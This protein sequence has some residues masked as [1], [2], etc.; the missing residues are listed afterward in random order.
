MGDELF[1]GLRALAFV[2]V[3]RVEHLLERPLR[4]LIVA[5]LAGA[6]LAVPVEAEA[7]LVQ[8]LAVAL[9]VRLGGD[10]R[11]LTCLYGILL[12][13]QAIG[14]VAHRVEH[15]EALLALEAR[16]DIAGDVSQRMSHMQSGTARVGEHVEHVVLFLRCILGHLVG[17]LF[18]PARL[19]LLLN[20]SEI[21]IHCLFVY[22]FFNFSI[23]TA[24]NLHKKYEFSICISHFFSFLL[25]LSIPSTV[26]R[27][28]LGPFLSVPIH[29]KRRPAGGGTTGTAA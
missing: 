3:E 20:L 27:R 8:L 13:R 7:Y 12:G 15:V 17:F 24:A 18:H 16:V 23:K 26:S 25:S 5:R 1:N 11:V 9:D 29:R 22:I 2:A 28:L 19:P 14:I 21:V 6:H 4:P 10:G